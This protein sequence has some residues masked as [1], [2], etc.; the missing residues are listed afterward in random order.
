MKAPVDQPP[1]HT[2]QGRWGPAALICL[3]PPVPEPGSGGNKVQTD[4]GSQGEPWP[5]WH[6][7][8]AGFHV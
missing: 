2:A 8:H 5:L 6:P 7:S 1:N 4:R 3:S